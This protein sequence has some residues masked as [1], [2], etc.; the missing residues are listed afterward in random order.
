M[1][2]GHLQGIVIEMEIPFR[3]NTK[4]VLTLYLGKAD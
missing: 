2:M 1:L 3:A 4:A